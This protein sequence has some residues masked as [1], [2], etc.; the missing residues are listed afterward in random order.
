MKRSRH[1]DNP[2]PQNEFVAESK[3]RPMELD[4]VRQ[5]AWEIA[6]ISLYF[7]EIHQIWASA[8]GISYPQW[9][10]LMA[11]TKP[12]KEDGVAVNIVAKM[13]HVEPSF[14]TSQSKALEKE[15]FLYRRPSS[16]DRR[17]V[18]LSLSEKT[19]RQLANLIGQQTTLEEFIFMDFT[20]AE[21][22]D[23]IAMLTTLKL[24]IGK[25]RHKAALDCLGVVLPSRS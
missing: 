7:A 5:L 16:I 2:L 21:R 25:V 3:T 10:I 13:L 22:S 19:R 4:P 14:V 11:L 8:L 23:F 9:R 24:R 15:G 18:Q 6:S 17:V 20:A 1:T 12:A